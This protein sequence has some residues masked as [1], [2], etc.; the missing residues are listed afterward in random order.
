MFVDLVALTRSRDLPLD[1]R[2]RRCGRAISTISRLREQPRKLEECK[3][4]A[5][6]RSRSKDFF[7]FFDSIQVEIAPLVS[8]ALR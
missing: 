6:E 2:F 1:R 4:N 5:R 3:K 7:E 8:F